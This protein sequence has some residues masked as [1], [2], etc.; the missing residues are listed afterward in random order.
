MHLKY[1]QNNLRVPRDAILLAKNGI[2]PTI[3]WCC[4]TNEM[5]TILTAQFFMLAQRCTHVV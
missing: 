5:Q 1:I 2:G 3:A 4:S